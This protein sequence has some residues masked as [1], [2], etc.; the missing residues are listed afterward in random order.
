M[1]CTATIGERA[2]GDAL[3]E[4]GAF[5]ALLREFRIEANL[6]QEEL[7]SAALVAVRT[8]SDLERGINQTA[9]KETARR[10]ADGLH[11]TGEV[12]AQFEALARGHPFAGGAAVVV[13]RRTLPRDIPFFTG[14]E[15]ELSALA[16]AT[17]REGVLRVHAIGGMAGVGKTAFAV[18]AAHQLADEFPD[19]QLFLQLHGHTPGRRPADSADALASLLL[20]SGVPAAGIPAD[21]E[22]RAALWRDRLADRRAILIL[23]DATDSEQIR[24]LL[25]GGEGNLVLVTT[26]RH[27]PALDSAQTVSL[28]TLPADEAAELLVRLTARP[29]LAPQDP[30]IRKIARLC[31]YLPLALGMLAARL[32]H[33]PAWTVTDVMAE[34]MAARDRLEMMA[35]ENISVIAAF[36]LSYQDLSDAQQRIFRY[37]GL[38]PGTDF[39]PYAA[40]ALT[41]DGLGATR[42]NLAAIYDHYLLAELAR[43]QYR[44]HD[45]IRE[46]ARSLTIERDPPADRDAAIGRLLGYFLRAAS[47]AGRQ[48]AERPWAGAPPFPAGEVVSVPEFASRDE[49]AGWL[50]MQRGNILDCIAFAAIGPYSAYALGLVRTVSEHLV[51]DGHWDQAHRAHELARAA[52]SQ[53]ADGADRAWSLTRLAETHYMRDSYGAAVEAAAEAV[54]QYRDLDDRQGLADALVIL[55]DA[56]RMLDHHYAEAVAILTEAIGIYRE[57]TDPW[58][59]ARALTYIGGIQVGRADYAAAMRS[60]TEALSVSREIGDSRDQARALT[61]LSAAQYLTGDVPAAIRSVKAAI[62]LY[63]QLGSTYGEAH[64]L[65]NLGGIQV[66]TGEYAEAIET[67]TDALDIYRDLGDR[68]GQGNAYTYLGDAYTTTGQFAEAAEV[69]DQAL[70]IY[71][72]IGNNPGKA[73]VYRVRGEIA[74]RTGDQAAASLL[75]RALSIYQEDGARLGEADALAALGDVRRRAGQLDAAAAALG[76]ALDIFREIGDLRGQADTLNQ[77]GALALDAGE[78]TR[79]REQHTAALDLAVETGSLLEQADALAGLGRCLLAIG[80]TDAGRTRLSRALEIYQ[81]VGSPRAAALREVSG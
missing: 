75:E 1:P 22:T 48:V 21:P 65:M 40:A 70:G 51:A 72:D 71:L 45:L 41:A 25:P 66:A 15:A 54:R 2:W 10:L 9:Q 11:L 57:I 16:A 23:D 4:P 62:P 32:H 43:D 31:G 13:A 80:E 76:R 5:A 50:A 53:S 6:T 12:R 24:P 7:A 73:N 29:G 39:D 17:A 59:E 52:A 8:I 67:L 38:H 63:R 19:G 77:L 18:H 68:L 61:Y 47:A 20:M 35:V 44:M 69:L 60:L 56:R 36:D 49:A 34:L 30:G 42:R 28:D 55:G 58:G 79:A 46:H 81:R 33:H 26:R 3:A 37:L 78:T 14:R 74:R 27:L 64:A